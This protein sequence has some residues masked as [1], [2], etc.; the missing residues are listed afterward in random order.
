[1][2]NTLIINFK[3][4]NKPS[5]EFSK[6][7]ELRKPISVEIINYETL[8]RSTLEDTESGDIF[9]QKFEIIDDLTVKILFITLF[10][11][12]GMI[13]GFYQVEIKE[14]DFLKERQCRAEYIK[15]K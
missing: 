15:Y 14:E 1:M 3:K 11:K 9:I 5:S 6:A 7:F 13:P 8:G 2:S 4:T 10:K 12:S